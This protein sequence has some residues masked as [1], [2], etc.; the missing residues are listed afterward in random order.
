VFP[1]DT[2]PEKDGPVGLTPSDN[3]VVLHVPHVGFIVTANVLEV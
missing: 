1:T 2:F 3:V